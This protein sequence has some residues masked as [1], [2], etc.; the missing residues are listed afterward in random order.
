MPAKKVQTKSK[1][2]KRD[3]FDFIK[4]ATRMDSNLGGEILADLK[5]RGV[6]IE[7]LHLRIVNWGYEA[8][9]LEDVK[10]LVTIYR[11]RT[12]VKNAVNDYAY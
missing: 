3:I 8:V 10:K 11:T 5:K 7:D 12:R 9:S 2:T 1:K 4:D 6:K